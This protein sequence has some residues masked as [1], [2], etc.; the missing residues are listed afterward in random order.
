MLLIVYTKI[1]GIY[2]SHKSEQTFLWSGICLIHTVPR[3]QQNSDP[4]DQILELKHPLGSNKSAQLYYNQLQKCWDTPKNKRPLLLQIAAPG[5]RSVRYNTDLP[6]PSH[7]KL[8]LQVLS[9]VLYC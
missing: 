3:N 8:F 4:T 9:M 7:S 1:Y 2:E 5:H 6:P